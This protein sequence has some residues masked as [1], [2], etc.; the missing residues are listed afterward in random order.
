MQQKTFRIEIAKGGDEIELAKAAKGTTEDG[1][2][3]YELDGETYRY[4]L[5]RRFGAIIA[6]RR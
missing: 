4:A 1:D 6:Y 3:V 2:L 5:K